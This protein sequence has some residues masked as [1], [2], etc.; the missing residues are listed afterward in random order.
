[1]LT[2]L[3]EPDL[4]F[5][6]E[7]VATQRQDHDHVL[8]LVRD[9]EDFL[10]QMLDDPKLVERLLKDEESLV[11]ISPYMLFS[12]LLREV[13]REVEK[14]GYVFEPETRGRRIAVFEAPA[15]VELLSAPEAREYLV[16][17][18]CSFVRTNT[19]VMYWR[20][21][22]TWHRRRFNDSNMDDMIALARMVD[23]D[24][25]PRYY[26]RVADIALFLSGIF[27]DQA[28][29]V[30]TRTR[31]TLRAERTLQDYEQEGQRFYSLAAK[32]TN[33]PGLQSVLQTLS[34]KF[35]LARTAL[36]SLSD[37]YLKSHRA[38]YFE[39]PAETE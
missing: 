2:R 4:R 5:L 12:V 35:I 39:L 31:S 34:T 16:H 8:E 3:T 21:H 23:P 36:N 27:P 28:V 9:K 11:R 32:E 15:V 14:R 17:L 6:V 7:T 33:E 29:R 1:M 30:A 25:K 37:S 22:G 10:E 24:L 13:R 38:R 20:E 18:L 26:Q 19:G